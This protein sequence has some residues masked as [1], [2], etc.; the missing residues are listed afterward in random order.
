MGD[1]D[2]ETIYWTLNANNK[3]FFP[4]LN[5]VAGF[6]MWHLDVEFVIYVFT[7]RSRRP[8]YLAVLMIVLMRV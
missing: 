5:A 3:L 2:K 7:T 1:R 6:E 4:P 8:K